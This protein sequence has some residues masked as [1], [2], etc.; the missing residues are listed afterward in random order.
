MLN[1]H[2]SDPFL[3]VV[4]QGGLVVSPIQLLTS[5]GLRVIQQAPN[6]LATIELSTA[7]GSL[8]TLSHPSLL[9]LQF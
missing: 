1:S 9:R 3:Q 8:P 6:G 7:N 5:Q 4:P 2:H